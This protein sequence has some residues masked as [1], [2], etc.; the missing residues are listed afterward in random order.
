MK[1]KILIQLIPLILLFLPLTATPEK[2]SI[3]QI[4]LQA[5]ALWE[6]QGYEGAQTLYEQ[7]LAQPLTEWQQA[8]LQYNLGTI[9]LAQHQTTEAIDRFQKIAPGQLS[10]PRFGQNLFLNEGI[11]YLQYEKALAPNTPFYDQQRIYLQQSLNALNQAQEEECKL[12]QF[13]EKEKKSG[14]SPQH[15]I[16]E[17]TQSALLQLHAIDQQKAKRWMESASIES[18]A[19]FLSI[20]LQQLIAETKTFQEQTK[21]PTPWSSYFQKQG[22]SLAS[23]WDALK[24]KK[25]S[26]DALVSFDHAAADYLNA[27]KAFSKNDFAGA[28]SNLEHSSQKLGPLGY[29]E[30]IALHLAQLNF[31]I[32]L[33]QPSLSSSDIQIIQW[34]IDQLKVGKEQA[35]VVALIKQS[36]ELGL[37]ALN[38][39][40]LLK[41]R[42]FLLAGYGEL[43]SLLPEK[44]HSAIS[45]LKDALDQANRSFQLFLI[46]QLI[47]SSD[48]QKEKLHAILKTEQK[49]VLTRA[50]LF[51]PAVLKEQ[52][53]R[54]HTVNGPGTGCQQSPWDQVIPLFDHGF[55]AAQSGEKLLTDSATNM[56]MIAAQQEQTLYDWQQAFNLLLNPPPQSRQKQGGGASSS[57][58][59]NLAETYRLIQEM[60]L[61]DQAQKTPEHGEF[62]SW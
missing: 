49:A 42:F 20:L 39:K 58:P 52:N 40:E 6:A 56:Q 36:L 1:I 26:P 16:E 5:E 55:L 24:Q 2:E 23:L 18:L 21:T 4:S 37:E 54:F 53:S 47:P 31:E 45:A 57:A 44:D 12:Q 41:A 32:L 43:D 34:G 9:R 46:A 22:E 30:N 33:L 14:C 15:V 48:S 17:W 28:M 50:I 29:K 51:I 25:F 3:S 27:L 35:E 38:G 61:E 59:K 11:A 10:L 8:R 7:L 19:T 60:Y 62:H 13:E